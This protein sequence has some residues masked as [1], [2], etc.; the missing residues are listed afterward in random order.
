LRLSDNSL[1]TLSVSLGSV[2]GLVKHP[3]KPILYATRRNAHVVSSI[4]LSQQPPTVTTIAGTLNAAGSGDGMGTSASFRGPRGITTDGT[5]LYVADAGNYTIR[6]IDLTTFAVSTLAGVPGMKG[7]VDGGLGISRL[8]GPTGI[9]YGNGALRFADTDASDPNTGPS[10][11]RTVVLANN[12]VSTLAGKL[13]PASTTARPAPSANGNGTSATFADVFGLTLT[14]TTIY[15][16]ERRLGTVRSILVGQANQTNTVAGTPA[17][18]GAV[19]GSGALARFWYPASVVVAGQT[20][21][22]TDNANATLRGVDLASGDV[23]TLAGLAGARGAVDGPAADARFQRPE[24]LTAI[25][26]TLFLGDGDDSSIRTLNLDTGAVSLFA[27]EHGA[28]GSTDGVG[29]A[30]RFGY[31]LY[32]TTDNARTLYLVDGVRI[33]TIDTVSA[34][35]TTIAGSSSGYLD[36]VG[37]AA[38]FASPYGLALDGDNLYICDGANFRIRALNVRTKEVTTF[39]GGAE[40]QR[41]DGT[42]DVVRFIHPSI[43]VGTGRGTLYVVDAGSLR[44]IDIAT[45]TTKTLIGRPELERRLRIGPLPGSFFAPGGLALDDA[46]DLILS[47][48]ITSAVVR[49]RIPRP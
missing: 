47:D 9:A 3:S 32:L 28:T 37:T 6:R 25:G 20:A 49:I 48:T 22:V 41:I 46:G 45:R 1:T 23:R 30:A 39:L 8:L 33:R 7:A 16:T 43:L 2:G 34:K 12:S 35:V 18:Y 40:S 10:L 24:S 14:A 29:A 15:V 21:Y 5:A 42:G 44:Q 13:P 19:D 26:R 11:I 17:K 31:P 38:R 4:D 27:G 36:A